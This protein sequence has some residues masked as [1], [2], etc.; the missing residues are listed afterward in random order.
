[1]R[2]RGL[3]LSESAY[4][5]K[6]PS[7][8]EVCT[9]G[10]I[11]ECWAPLE[12]LVSLPAAASVDCARGSTAAERTPW[13]CIHRYRAVHRRTRLRTAACPFDRGGSRD[14]SRLPVLAGALLI[15]P[16]ILIGLLWVGIALSVARGEIVL[17]A[18]FSSSRFWEQAG[19]SRATILWTMGTI[20]HILLKLPGT[21]AEATVASA[22]VPGSFR[23]I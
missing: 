23:R 21:A 20:I 18:R 6:P 2:Q 14:D 17:A 9:Q 10:R 1:M 12:F 4:R 8:H 3:G 7:L 15:G 13:A 22:A 11:H 19:R 16:W 5:P